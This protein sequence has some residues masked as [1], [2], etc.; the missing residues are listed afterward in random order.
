MN[1]N[2]WAVKVVNRLERDWN[3]RPD[4]TTIGTF[5][6]VSLL[7][8]DFLDI[9]CGYGRFYEWLVANRKSNF[10]YIGYDSSEHMID[11][12]YERNKQYNDVFFVKDITEP[13]DHEAE[14]ILC[15]E[16]LIHLTY[17]KQIKVLKN[18]NKTNAKS[19][20]MTIQSSIHP[21]QEIVCLEKIDFFNIIQGSEKFSNDIKKIISGVYSIQKTRHF[22]RRPDTFK[23]IFV[24]KRH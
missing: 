8:S 10:D 22:I 9:G 15:N 7:G 6:M 24:V 18:I 11:K 16:V 13:F 23:D 1:I 12:A 4:H 3:R 5:E 14:I 21:R 2:N 19:V 20:V 17:D